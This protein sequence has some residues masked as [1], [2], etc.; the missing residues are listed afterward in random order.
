MTKFSDLCTAFTTARIG[1]K[2]YENDCQEFAVDIWNKMLEHFEIPPSQ[3]SLYKFDEYGEF[4]RIDPPLIC[5]M[6]LR[7]DSYFEFG[8]GITLYESPNTYPHETVILPIH[9]SIDTDGN[10]KA[11]LGEEGK[12]HVIDRANNQHFKDFLDN[13]FESVNA[14][15]SQ[16]LTDMRDKNTFRKIGF[17]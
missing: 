1:F 5:A 14:S 12:I 10:N 17:K 3:I 15:Y 4:E 6:R 16:G 7:S 11:K 9:V 2:K 8:I 13:I